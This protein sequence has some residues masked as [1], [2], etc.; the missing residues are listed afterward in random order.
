[1]TK[2]AEISR[3]VEEVALAFC[4][5]CLGWPEASFT[6]RHSI[7]ENMRRPEMSYIA[8]KMHGFELDPRDFGQVMNAVKE[9]CDITAVSLSLKY[10]PG[11]DKDAWCAQLAP[12]SE[13][14]GEDLCTC[15]MQ[16]CL[17]AHRKIG[18]SGVRDGAVEAKPNR[19]NP[20]SALDA[21]WGNIRE[22]APV[23]LAFC[24]ECMGWSGA[25]LINDFGYVYI[26]ERL[27]DYPV[28][29]RQRAFHCNEDHLDGVMEGMK[30][31]C[32]ADAVGLTLEY[33]PSGSADDCWRASIGEH[34]KADGDRACA[35]LM[36]ACVSAHRRNAVSAIMG[37]LPECSKK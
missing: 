35:A 26:T 1:M 7:Y 30:T 11:S 27:A 25:K 19:R 3:E 12:H 9:W 21:P 14:R 18:E 32:D 37:D 4:R 2:L 22:N 28:E 24:T 29:P 36:A 17:D 33:F 10:S 23:A 34:G 15:M 8:G 6:S 20:A 13:A 16:A 5:E 31:W